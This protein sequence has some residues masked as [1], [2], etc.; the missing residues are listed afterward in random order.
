MK[1]T[2]STNFRENAAPIGRT[3]AQLL[4]ALKTFD[5]ADMRG[6]LL[7]PIDEPETLSTALPGEKSHSLLQNITLLVQN[8]IL[9][10]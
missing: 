8:L 6:I 1:A 9:S 4:R 3:T 7:R 5:I 2:S 10:A